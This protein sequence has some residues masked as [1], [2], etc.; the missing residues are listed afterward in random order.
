[1]LAVLTE[2]RLADLDAL[3]QAKPS[4]LREQLDTLLSRIEADLPVVS[5]AIAA[6]FFSHLQ[7]SRHLGSQNPGR[8][9]PR[10]DELPGS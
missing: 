5:E 7:T 6:S 9:P 1:V 4:G 10:P 8:I 3:T 2:L